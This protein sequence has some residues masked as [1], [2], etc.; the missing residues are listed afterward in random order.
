MVLIHVA[1]ADWRRGLGKP[2]VVARIGTTYPYRSHHELYESIIEVIDVARARVRYRTR[3]PTFIPFLLGDREVGVLDE[4]ED[5]APRLRV[6]F[7]RLPADAGG[8]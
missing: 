1:R 6:G 7:F 3:F 2:V 5:G 8:R 4:D